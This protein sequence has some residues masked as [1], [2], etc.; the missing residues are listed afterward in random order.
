MILINGDESGCIDAGDRGFQYG[1][2]LFETM[3]ISNSIPIFLAAHLDRLFDGAMRLSIPMPDRKLLE[4]E[5]SALAVCQPEGVLKIIVTRGSGGRG[6]RLPESQRP[7]RVLTTHPKPEYPET[8]RDAGIK[9]VLCKTRLGHNPQLAGIKHLNR[10]EQV[11]A[12]SEWQGT[13]ILE[14]LMLDQMGF[15]VEGTMSNVFLVEGKCLYTPKLDRCGV[16]GIIR[17]M[18]I[19]HARRNNFVVRI[20]R[21]TLARFMQA[22]EI[23]FTNSIIGVWP[24]FRFEAHRYRVGPISG[25]LGNWLAD[26]QQRESIPR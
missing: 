26:Q 6:Y 23:F 4:E 16:A 1:D 14:G 11:L 21:I 19:D 17:K 8:V 24:V 18:I 25:Q 10:L 2:G 7:L 22:E 12:R 5:A 20:L 3:G 13:D 9:A 15:V